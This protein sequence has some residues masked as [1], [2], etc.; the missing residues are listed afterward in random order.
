MQQRSTQTV[1]GSILNSQFKD[2]TR[3]LVFFSLYD[4]KYMLFSVYPNAIW[5][6][7]TIKPTTP[8]RLPCFGAQ[9]DPDSSWEEEFAARLL[10]IP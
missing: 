3:D 4:L 7:K 8:T 5:W 9:A 6:S 10:M 1:D 2:D